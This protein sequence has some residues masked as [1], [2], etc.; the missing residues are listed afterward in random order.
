MEE[1]ITTLHP[2]GKQGVNISREEYGEVKLTILQVLAE[3]GEMTFTDLGREVKERL[4]PRFEGSV[5]CYYTTAKLDLE[6]R[7][8]IARVPG[9]K[10]Q[11]LGLRHS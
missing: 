4:L 10:P 3:H 11:R 6:A 5:S 8:L 1:R 7:G 2:R 9:S